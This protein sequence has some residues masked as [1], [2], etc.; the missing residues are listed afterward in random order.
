MPDDLDG[1]SVFAPNPVRSPM[2]SDFG[3]T[4]AGQ[5]ELIAPPEFDKPPCRNRAASARDGGLDAVSER[6]AGNAQ[7]GGVLLAKEIAAFEGELVEA[8]CAAY[9][10]AMIEDNEITERMDAS[11]LRLHRRCVSDAGRYQSRIEDGMQHFHAWYRHAL[12]G[13]MAQAEIGA[14]E[15][16]LACAVMD[17]MCWRP[18]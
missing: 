4:Y 9:M 12:A 5:D 11:H 13:D 16:R 6:A 1:E 15:E 7:R 3:W 2:P 8:Q 17:C 10:E 14:Q 18:S